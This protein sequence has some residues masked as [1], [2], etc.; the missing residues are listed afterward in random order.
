[1][2][3]CCNLALE[4]TACPNAWQTLGLPAEWYYPRVVICDI[5][6]VCS[7]LGLDHEKDAEGKCGGKVHEGCISR[8]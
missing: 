1:M 8:D 7:M 6:G 3:M 2:F 5:S 4:E